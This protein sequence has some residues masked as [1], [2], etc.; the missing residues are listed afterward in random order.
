MMS[1]RIA[2]GPVIALLCVS[3]LL[4]A[5]LTGQ[6]VKQ[7]YNAMLAG[8]PEQASRYEILDELDGILRANYYGS[9]D[10]AALRRAVA[11]GYVSGLPDGYSRYLTAQEL[12]V[13]QSEAIGDMRGI[14]VEPGRTA[15]GRIRVE[16][17]LDGSP[18][19]QEGIAVG[20]VI[21][22]VDSVPVNASNY[23]ETVQKISGGSRTSVA[24]TV[25]GKAGERTLTLPTGFEAHS[26]SDDHYEDVGYLRLT[27]FYAGTAA[28]VQQAVDAF[29]QSGVRGLVIDLRK[30]KSENVAFAMQTLDV[31]VPL[32]EEPAARLVDQKGET[33]ESF[34]TDAAAVN[35]PMA[36]LV[37]SGT[38]AAAELFACNLRAFGKASL[39]GTRTGG[40]GLVRKAFKLSNG[41]AVLLCVGEMLPCRGE[42]FNG[43]GLEPDLVSAEEAQSDALSKDGQFLAAV[44]ALRGEDAETKGETAS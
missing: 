36:V 31:F 8:L 6:I 35:L 16:D 26:L 18:A 44:A 27:E 23:D 37:S 29:Q 38:K 25:R 7:N 2:L 9:S 42:S 3:I 32:S 39:V 21:M 15:Q 11:K 1:K 10:N 33:V 12:Q 5:V 14:G 13:Y 22:A 30:N 19:K 41:D 24:L 20:D 40:L 43:V 28:Q 17:V 4:T 34:M